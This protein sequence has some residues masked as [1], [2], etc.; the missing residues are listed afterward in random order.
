MWEASAFREER[1]QNPN[2]HKR[3]ATLNKNQTKRKKKKNWQEIANLLAQYSVSNRP[4]NFNCFIKWV[5]SGWWDGNRHVMWQLPENLLKGS[6]HVPFV[7]FSSPFSFLLVWMQTDG[8]NLSSY[9][10]SWDSTLGLAKH[11][12]RR[13]PSDHY[14]S[15]EPLIFRLCSSER[16][17]PLSSVRNVYGF[18]HLQL[19]LMVTDRNFYYECWHQP[20]FYWKDFIVESRYNC[21]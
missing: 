21:S 9:D 8:W 18:C 7:S 13:S 11:Q 5:S 2:L 10:N 6:W 17:R 12:A 3:I 16:D 14:I 1:K 19:N 15:P 20:L 4:F